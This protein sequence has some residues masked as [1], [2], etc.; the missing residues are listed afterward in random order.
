IQNK[1]MT[2]YV[3]NSGGLRNHP[4][5]ARDF[6]TNVVDGLGKRPRVLI[7]CFAK[8]R[9]EW[10]KKFAEDKEVIPKL[11]PKGVSPLFDLAF[12]STFERQVKAS[13]AIY[14]Q[15]G[16]DHLVMYWLRKFDI[17]KIWEGKTIATNSASS[18]ALSKHFWTCDWRQC[19][20]GLGI[21]PIKFLSHYNSTYGNDD[22]RGPINWPAAY[23][24]LKNYGNRKLPIHALEEGRFITIETKAG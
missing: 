22:L 13:D 5:M 6:F 21:L 24:Q 15:G 18:H 20:D 7:C 16:D 4:G 3:L 2:K 9:E 1:F 8:P 10:E 23:E 14:I 12:P 11:I 17:P 19:M